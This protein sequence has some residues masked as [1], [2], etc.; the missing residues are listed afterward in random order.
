MTGPL[1]VAANGMATVSILLAGRNSLHTWWTGIAGCVLFAILFEQA[2][3]Y[4]DAS[5]QVFFIVASLVG[6]WHW[7]HGGRDRQPLPIRRTSKPALLLSAAAGAAA[8]IGYGALLHAWTDAYAPFLDSMVLSFS[9]LAQVLMIQRRLESWP[10]W[11]LVNTVAVPLF[12]S[13]G[14]Y[15]TAALYAV[16]WI[17]ALVS[18]R[19]WW[20]LMRTADASRP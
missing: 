9:V 18:W 15:V 7:L 2:R 8:A 3:L 11:L 12:A 1:E 17:N 20:K 13:R 5:L 6:W 19:H 4:A 14:L 16:Y 10:F